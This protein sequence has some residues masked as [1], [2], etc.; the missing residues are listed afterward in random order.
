MASLIRT[1]PKT[2]QTEVTQAS[3]LWVSQV[4]RLHRPLASPPITFWDGF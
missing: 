1:Y 2:M 3:R 4:S